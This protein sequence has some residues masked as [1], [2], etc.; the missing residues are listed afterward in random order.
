VDE[1]FEKSLEQLGWAR[2]RNIEIEYRYIEGRQDKI[3]PL[4]AELVGLGPDLFVA[5][6]PPLA[7]A[8]KQA[9]PQTPVVFLG[10]ADP[11]GFGV[12][13]NLARP[14]GNVTGIAGNASQQIAAKRLELLKEAVPSLAR[15]HRWCGADAAVGSARATT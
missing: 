13:S 5:W 10:H 6:G 12:V 7:L 3:G 15:A 1:A 4:V 11:I 2:D 9:A 8:V 14:G